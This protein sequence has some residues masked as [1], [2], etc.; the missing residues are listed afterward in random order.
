MRSTGR[1]WKSAYIHR[2]LLDRCDEQHWQELC[3]MIWR[4][5]ADLLGTSGCC[6]RTLDE[7]RHPADDSRWMR[8]IH[9]H[10]ADRT[11]KGGPGILL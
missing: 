11:A 3:V 1:W 7:N 6:W 2:L 8:C 5:P 9:C 10:L 4:S